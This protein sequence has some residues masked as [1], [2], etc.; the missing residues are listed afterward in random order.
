MAKR[1]K[2][3]MYEEV[4][5]RKG[6]LEIERADEPVTQETPESPS[7]NLIALEF[8]GQKV[9]TVT[10]DGR[11]YFVANDVAMC[12]GYADLVGAITYHCKGARSIP[13]PTA[14]GR[15][16]AKIIPESDVF[17]LIN[18]SI[19]PAAE[20]FKDWMNEAVLPS[21]GKTGACVVSGATL[22]QRP[23]SLASRDRL[24]RAPVG[25][26]APEAELGR[27]ADR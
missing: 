16:Q 4:H 5:S 15:Q 14:G 7:T 1:F 18:G 17:R 22:G 9:R 12:L 24:A 6:P 11:P 19:L 10:K 8:D 20:R 21:I 26:P 23:R 2:R 3:W 13:V 25:G 27:H